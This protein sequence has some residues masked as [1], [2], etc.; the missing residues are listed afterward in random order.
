MTTSVLFHSI[1]QLF[2]TV[3][4]NS[5]VSQSY[6]Y[7]Y[8]TFCIRKSVKPCKVTQTMASTSSSEQFKSFWQGR[9]TY[10]VFDYPNINDK[11]ADYTTSVQN[12]MEREEQEENVYLSERAF[13]P[14][15]QSATGVNQICKISSDIRFWANYGS[16][17]FCSQCSSVSVKVLP[18]NFSNRTKNDKSTKCIY[19]HSRGT[20]S[21]CTRTSQR[22]CYL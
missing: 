16:W 13:L 21:L 17:T 10:L 18:H 5:K 19:V 7:N 15:P 20:L 2:S 4:S 1:F 22:L 6:C 3:I 14:V 12:R 9:K 11:V 8:G